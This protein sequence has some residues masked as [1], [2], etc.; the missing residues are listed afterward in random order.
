MRKYIA[1][2]HDFKTGPYGGA[3]QFIVALER[4]FIDQGHMVTRNEVDR[5]TDFIILNAFLFD[6]EL[7]RQALDKY[8][9]VKILHRI[10]GPL[11]DYRGAD[12]GTDKLIYH[13]NQEFADITVYQSYYSYVA[14]LQ[15]GMT[16]INPCVI[17]NA[18]SPLFSRSRHNPKRDREKRIKLV[19]SS[20]SSNIRKGKLYYEW[21]DKYLDR[22]KYTF[23]YI[24]NFD[25]S[26]K[27]SQ[28]IASLTAES[29]AEELV[30]HD[31]YVTA[32]KNDPCS[33]SLIEALSS[34]LPAVYM[35]SGGHPEIVGKGGRHFSDFSDLQRNIDACAQNYNQYKKD[36]QVPDISDIAEEYVRVSNFQKAV[37]PRFL[38]RMSSKVLSL[39]FRLAR[40]L[41]T[42]QEHWTTFRKALSWQVDYTKNSYTDIFARAWDIEKYADDIN[43]PCEELA[44]PISKYLSEEDI[45]FNGAPDFLNLSIR[46]SRYVHSIY[47]VSNEHVSIDNKTLHSIKNL[48]FVG[49]SVDINSD[50]CLIVVC[51]SL[52]DL[53]NN[54]DIQNKLCQSVVVITA[55]FSSLGIGNSTLNQHEALEVAKNELTKLLFAQGFVSKS[56]ELDINNRLVCRAFRFDL[57]QEKTPRLYYGGL[58]VSENELIAGGKVKLK[59]LMEKYPQYLSSFNILYLVAT[60]LPKIYFQELIISAKSKGIKLVVNQNGVGFSG[61]AGK[62]MSK[63][64]QRLQFLLDHADY[65]IYQSAFSRDSSELF[66]NTSNSPSTIIYNAVDTE[67]YRPPVN[68]EI[69]DMLNLL[70]IGSHYER[71]RV[72]LAIDAVAALINQGVAVNLSIYGRY[73]W[74]KYSIEELTEYIRLMEVEG[75]ISVKGSYSQLE[76]IQIYQKA[77]I[78]LHLKYKD[79]CPT[80]PI[81]AMACGVPVIGSNSGGLP[82]LVRDAGVLIDVP[83]SW[84]QLF[85]PNVPSIIEAVNKI[86]KNYIQYSYRARENVVNNFTTKVFIEQHEKALTSLCM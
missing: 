40:K 85:Y 57:N 28:H 60:A 59:H 43:I 47:H 32:S 22:E 67:Q 36:I 48:H 11:Q 14:H 64:N 62:Q 27:N 33:N 76:A 19:A 34:G 81:E 41:S 55:D 86:S 6:R 51:H 35:N 54:S 45:L 31:I 15:K 74:S 44:V 56:V 30:K 26:L 70:V 4:A 66:L 21:L 61:W 83:D 38:E 8:P 82:E 23:T 69:S 20:W 29:L 18:A 1:L 72:F 10:D 78:L 46:L 42:R 37:K 50:F 53:K 58:H 3:N 71:E 5:N 12:D 84:E 68:K 73:L 9:K 79:P 65:V 52:N 63:V 77:D 75:H 25:G 24:G 7:L 2:F 39:T 49:R 80:V 17:S 13:I 16:M